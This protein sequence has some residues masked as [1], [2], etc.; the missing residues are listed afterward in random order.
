MGDRGPLAGVKVIELGGIGPGP[1]AG[2]V[3]A[4]LGADVVRVRRPGGVV[5]PAEDRDL[6]HRGKRIV[7]LDVKARPQTLVDLAAKADVLLDCFRPGTCER[8][9]IGPDDCAAVNP[10]LIFA[11]VTGWGQDGPLASTAGHDINYLSSTGALSAMGYADRPPTPPLNLVAD[12]GGGSMLVLVGIVA[13]LY[14]RERSGRGQVID[15]AMVD[16][17]SLLSQMMWTMKSTGAL[18]D[19]RESFLLDGGT[20]F[21]RCYET[22]DGRYVAVGA[23]EPQFFA[24]LLRGLELSPD[25][26]PNQLDT[27]SY[28]RMRDTFA[29]RFAGRTRDAWVRTFAGT[30][31]CVTPVLTWGEAATDGHLRARATVITAHGADQAAPAPRFSRTPAGPVG[32]PPAATTPLTEINW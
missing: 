15:A 16:G 4:D 32:P 12:F 1:H 9:G 21:Y 11:R 3:L 28:A 29:E 19:R 20:P 5:M 6:L 17:V 7:D 24:A 13:A 8:L 23:I 2:M 26:V 27:G 10:R 31:A 22:S 25:E 18:R 30:D 14:E